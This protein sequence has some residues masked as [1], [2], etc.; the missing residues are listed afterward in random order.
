MPASRVSTARPS[1]P[2][3]TGAK[4]SLRAVSTTH[5]VTTEM[6]IPIPSSQTSASPNTA[7][8]TASLRT[9]SCPV[10]WRKITAAIPITSPT[11]L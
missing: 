7:V 1:E 11:T 2:R 4:N 6:T 8:R 5:S 3:R 9:A 10:R